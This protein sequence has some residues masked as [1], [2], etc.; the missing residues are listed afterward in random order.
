MSAF[1]TMCNST[2]EIRIHAHAAR[3]GVQAQVD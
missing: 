1:A 2:H 3:Q